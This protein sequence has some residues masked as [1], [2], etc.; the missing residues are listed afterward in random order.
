[1][2]SI[3]G[4]FVLFLTKYYFLT[5]QYFFALQLQFLNI[6]FVSFGT[7]PKIRTILVLKKIGNKKKLRKKNKNG[8]KL[9]KLKI[10]FQKINILQSLF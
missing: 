4:F 5:Q 2:Y 8:E 6:S 3:F 9:Q 1:M 7:T 10:N